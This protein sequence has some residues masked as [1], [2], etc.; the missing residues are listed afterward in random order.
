M[1]LTE[2]RDRWLK[3]KGEY[4]RFNSNIDEDP[5]A[6][7]SARFIC[8]LPTPKS[9]KKNG[10][11]L[12][13]DVTD[14]SWLIAATRKKY[15]PVGLCNNLR[16]AT[17][18][19]ANLRNQNVPAYIVVADANALP[20][21]KDLF[22]FVWRYSPQRFTSI[23]DISAL[24]EKLS[25][26]LAKSGIAKISFDNKASGKHEQLNG[27]LL[28]DTISPIS[29]PQCKNQ[30][31]QHLSNV[32][33]SIQKCFGVSLN[34]EPLRGAGNTRIAAARTMAWCSQ[35]IQS[36]NHFSQSVY[37]SATK[38][39]GSPNFRIHH[40]LRHH[41]LNQNLN[42]V[43]LLQCPISGG[44]VYLSKDGDFVISDLASVKYPVV[45]DIP[46]MLREAAVDLDS[47]KTAREALKFFTD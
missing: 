11:F 31:Q 35:Y 25:Y 47:N 29:F 45:H 8:D 18:C 3:T 28:N 34:D 2:S 1:E 22:D 41:W 42:I 16:S 6:E 20:F 46:V 37:I 43:Y 19:L 26:V 14:G 39:T 10:L 40:F 17:L 30:F 32:Q 24:A 7:Y 12:D 36:L 21:Q 44:P 15:L 38:N 13:L 27:K 5:A 9:R 4:E 33:G 23:A